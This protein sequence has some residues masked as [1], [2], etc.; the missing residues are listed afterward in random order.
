MS[1]YNNV[2]TEYGG[3][4]FDSKKEAARYQQLL[5][6]EAAGKI[7]R[8][9]LQP[10]Y[11]IVVQG[12]PIKIRSKKCPNGRKVQYVAD[13]EYREIG[14]D[15]IKLVIEDVKGMKTPVYKLKR[16][17]MEAMGYEITEI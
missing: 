11:D 16:A 10:R 5:L 8:L 3:H 9:R 4:K 14:K 13:F 15:S 7:S 17:L 1:K 6:L 12:I 2:K